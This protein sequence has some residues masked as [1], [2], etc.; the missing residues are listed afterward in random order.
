[1]SIF[2]ISDLHLSLTE[3][4]DLLHPERMRLAKPM[5]VFGARWADFLPRLIDGWRQTVGEQDTVLLPGDLSWALT[6]SEARYDLQFLAA[7]PGRKVLIKG[8]HDYWW[9]SLRQLRALLDP[10]IIALQHSA[11]AVEGWAVCGV[12]GWLLPQHGNYQPAADDKVFARELLRLRMALDEAA[13]LKLPILLLMHYPP[14]DK[15]AVFEQ[16]AAIIEQYG[17]RYCLYGHVH[18][19]RAPAFEGELRGVQYLNCSCDR[20][21]L[22][23]RRIV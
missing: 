2:A 14:L 9:S 4:P 5:D 15:D 12:R 10:S 1:M 17:V 7:L 20:L 11:V 13:A 3:P 16:I 8:N 21:G 6:L 23:P 18:G 19:D 22:R